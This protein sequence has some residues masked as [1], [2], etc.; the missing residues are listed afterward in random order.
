MAV[1]PT[2]PMALNNF[3]SKGYADDVDRS[4]IDKFRD[5]QKAVYVWTLPEDIRGVPPGFIE[6]CLFDHKGVAIKNTSAMGF[7]VCACSPSLQDIYGMAVQ[8]MPSF[9][10]GMFIDEKAVIPPEVFQ[11][12]TTPALI[13]RMR[14]YDRIEPYLK[15]MS[16]SM[17]A[18]HS[19]LKYMKQWIAVE[20]NQGN[21]KQ[22]ENLRHA[23][24]DDDGVILHI[25]G[26]SG[27]PTPVDL[28]EK[29]YV[30][31][32]MSAYDWA[33]SKV[34]TY[35]CYNNRGTEKESGV[36]SQETTSVMQELDASAQ[37]GL[38]IRKDWCERVKNELGLEISVE[39]SPDFAEYFEEDRTLDMGDP[40]IVKPNAEDSEGFNG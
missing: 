18:I 36:T 28:I 12:S 37:L 3:L 5:L 15:I 7:I 8:W 29:D 4:L 40:E 1:L 11:P 24:E 2:K 21:D 32:S 17:K 38:E 27:M 10:R 35:L 31:P 19:N 30:M 6:D 34:L 39:L 33:Y 20:Y 14:T 16:A 9:T 13:F 26:S 23:L 25:P 22:V